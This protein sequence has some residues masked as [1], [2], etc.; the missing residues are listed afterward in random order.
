MSSYFTYKVN[1]LLA[2]RS[3]QASHGNEEGVVLVD[4]LVQ[5]LL[6]VSGGLGQ[7]V[8]LLDEV[9]LVALEARG[10]KSIVS[11]ALLYLSEAAEQDLNII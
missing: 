8:S 4:V 1:P 5:L 6:G 9:V 3:G 10:E 7:E 11:W 2:D